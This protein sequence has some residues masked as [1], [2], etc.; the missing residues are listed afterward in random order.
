MGESGVT[1]LSPKILLFQDIFFL[2]VFPYLV[3]PSTLWMMTIVFMF[4]VDIVHLDY[5]V[6]TLWT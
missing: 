1:L 4:Q 5:I 6:R 2:L 3:K